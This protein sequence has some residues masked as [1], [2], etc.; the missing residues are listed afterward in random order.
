MK[1]KIAQNFKPLLIFIGGGGV[2]YILNLFLTEFLTE[3]VGLYYLVSFAIVQAI[4]IVY[5]Y[6][7]ISKFVYKKPLSLKSAIKYMRLMV[8][9]ALVNIFVVG[10]ISELLNLYYLWSIA[11]VIPMMTI[12]KYFVYKKF[13]F[14]D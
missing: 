5:G 10:R 11:V 7:Y 8:V 13:A 9:F 12:V 6:F 4:L 2:N 1:E 14:N 3:T